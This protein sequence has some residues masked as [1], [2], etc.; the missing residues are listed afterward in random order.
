MAAT[1][2]PTTNGVASDVGA[3][4]LPE[5]IG[6]PEG[7]LEA[8]GVPAVAGGVTAA[9]EG[10][11]AIAVGTLPPAGAATTVIV[12]VICSGW[13]SQ[14]YWYVPAWVNVKE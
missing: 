2:A 9:A 3:P 11:L 4:L 7:A 12:P 8:D 6:V 14:K 13:I 10:A 5:P 1:M